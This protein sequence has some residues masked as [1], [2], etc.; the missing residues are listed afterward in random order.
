MRMRASRSQ[1]TG[2]LSQRLMDAASAGLASAMRFIR[3]K[4]D[5]GKMWGNMSSFRLSFMTCLRFRRMI[6]TL[7]GRMTGGK[8]PPRIRHIVDP[9]CLHAPRERH[10]IICNTLLLERPA[11][12]GSLN[13]MIMS[14]EES[15]MNKIRTFALLAVALLAMAASVPALAHG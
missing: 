1:S 15:V 4:K 5:C 12:S 2:M 10:V 8:Y 7:D 9:G 14:E 6:C 3:S 11:L 13:C